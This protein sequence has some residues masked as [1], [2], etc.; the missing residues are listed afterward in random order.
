[1]QNLLRSCLSAAL[2]VVAI[3][4][5]TVSLMATQATPSATAQVPTLTESQAVQLR[6]LEIQTE[7]AQLKVALAQAQ[8]DAVVREGSA[9]LATLQRDGYTLS[10]TDR[11]WTYT[12]KGAPQ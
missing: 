7:N 2:A 10:R 5:I 8:L 4:A 3:S 11:G 12:A 1:M 6:V 9:Y